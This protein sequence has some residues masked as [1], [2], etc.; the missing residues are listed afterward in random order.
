MRLNRTNSWPVGVWAGACCLFVPIPPACN[1]ARVCAVFG[2]CFFGASCRCQLRARLQLASAW[3]AG[4]QQ[5]QQQR[6]PRQQQCRQHWQR[7]WQQQQQQLF[8]QCLRTKA[9]RQLLSFKPETGLA[10]L[11]ALAALAGS[12]SRD[13]LARGLKHDNYLRTVLGLSVPRM[14]EK[15]LQLQQLLGLRTY[16]L[17]RLLRTAPWLLMYKAQTLE[18]KVAVLLAAFSQACAPAAA[19]AAAECAEFAP[20]AVN[21]HQNGCPGPSVAHS[22]ANWLQQQQEQQGQGLV[23]PGVPSAAGLTAL[24]HAVLHSPHLLG[25]S[26]DKVAQRLGVLQRLGDCSPGL[27]EQLRQG[28]ETGAIGRW[29]EAGA[30]CA[31][32]SWVCWASCATH[33]WVLAASLKHVCVCVRCTMVRKATGLKTHSSQVQW[34]CKQQHMYAAP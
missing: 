14:E 30:R 3:F 18:A 9:G 27:V 28:L 5:Q 22:Q 4:S 7:H 10:R 16:Q 2:E 15:A 11:Q 26:A 32:R 31:T 23:L 1:N 34:P 25:L 29:L 13:M 17:Q 6:K 8:V 20:C 33:S 19:A 21:G 24:Q 12:S